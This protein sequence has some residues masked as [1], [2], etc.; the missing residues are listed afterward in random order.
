MQLAHLTFYGVLY[1]INISVWTITWFFNTHIWWTIGI[2]PHLMKNMF[3]PVSMAMGFKWV[4]GMQCWC[5][6]SAHHK[7]LT[8]NHFCRISCA[9]GS[10]LWELQSIPLLDTILSAMAQKLPLASWLFCSQWHVSGAFSD[11]MESWRHMTS[12]TQH[13]AV[14][15]SLILKT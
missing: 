3:S 6:D 1:I 9:A 11:S 12:S 14:I 13:P 2:D 10:K 4:C 7:F 15:H 8:F 5:S